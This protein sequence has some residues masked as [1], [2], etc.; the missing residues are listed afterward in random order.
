MPWMNRDVIRGWLARHNWSVSRLARECSALGED[1]FPEGTMRN[2]VNG[3]D[4]AREGRIHVVAKVTAK[5]GDGLTY[6]ALV[7]P[8]RPTRATR[9]SPAGIYEAESD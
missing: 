7:A 9:T 5:F 8:N 1:T 4:P 3:I 6:E 2:V